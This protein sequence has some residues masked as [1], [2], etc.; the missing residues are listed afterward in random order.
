MPKK[1]EKTWRIPTA[2]VLGRTF[3]IEPDRE[4]A[5]KFPQMYKNDKGKTL[6][7]NLKFRL[8]LELDREN[9]DHAK[10]IEFLELKERHLLEENP[11]ARLFSTLRT[12]QGPLKNAKGEI[13]K[14][15]DGS[16]KQWIDDPTKVKLEL[17]SLSSI[18]I[19]GEDDTLL[20]GDDRNLPKG[21]KVDV[22]VSINTWT[23]NTKGEEKAG[24][25]LTPK[26]IAVVER[27]QEFTGKFKPAKSF[28][29]IK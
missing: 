4:F 25:R 23:S 17:S 13:L 15:P 29:E 19:Y 5:E 18:P 21:S 6:N 12:K 7:L 9:E 16:V 28:E 11:D 14:N 8:S 26:G 2:K 1:P 27:A 3:L 20:E 22:K 10:F 24:L